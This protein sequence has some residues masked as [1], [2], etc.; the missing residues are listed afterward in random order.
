MRR[1][2][3]KSLPLL[4]GTTAHNKQ[5]DSV[6]G[7]PSLLEEQRQV[8]H[9]PPSLTL[10]GVPTEYGGEERMRR[11]QNRTELGFFFHCG[12]KARLF[13]DIKLNL[14]DSAH[15]PENVFSACVLRASRQF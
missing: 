12:T 11:E 10:L 6:A 9:P 15:I 14:A 7:S 2:A 4:E 1:G 13:L 8:G 3:S 5:A